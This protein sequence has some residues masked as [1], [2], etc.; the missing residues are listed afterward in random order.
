VLVV[1]LLA[2]SA[3]AQPAE[4]PSGYTGGG[5]GYLLG[6]G[7]FDI[8][9]RGQIVG[10]YID[11]D[12]HVHGHLLDDGVFTRIEVPDGV[13]TTVHKVDNRGQVVGVYVGPDGIQHGFTLRNGRY[14]NVDFPGATHTG[15]NASNRRG[16]IVGY[17]V[18]GDL[19][20]PTVRGARLN[21]GRL[22]LFDA[23][24]PPS[25]PAATTAYVINDRGQ[26][27]GAK[28]PLPSG[29]PSPEAVMTL[30]S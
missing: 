21:H 11:E 12:G 10:A 25:G 27:V 13:G 4:P 30:V 28:L 2:G 9:D 22:T 3:S 18:E 24:G 23:P 15:V 1:L 16:E 5:Q 29:S 8:N 7:A 6:S 20:Q 19:S 14:H 26:I 17:F